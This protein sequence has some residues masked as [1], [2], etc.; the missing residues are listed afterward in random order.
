MGK[1][2]FAPSPSGRMHLG[3]ACSAL[4]SWLSARSADDAFSLRLEDLD[5]RCQSAENARLIVDD[6]AWL[7]LDWDEQL[8]QT[9][10]ISA[11]QSAFET[12]RARDH[13][14]PCFC[15]RADLHAASAPHASDGTPL[16]AGACRS[17]SPEQVAEKSLLRPPAYRIEVPDKTIEFTD[18]HL[19]LVRQ[20]LAAECGDFVLRRSD[21]VFAYQ[22][23]CVVDDALTGCTQVVR[24]DDLL[25]STPRQ[26]FL[27]DRLGYGAPQFFHHPMLLS[28]DGRRLSKRDRDLDLGELRARHVAPEGLVGKLA[29]MLGIIEQP[30]PCRPDELIGEFSWAKLPSHDLV[31]DGSE[32]LA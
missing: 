11:Y 21:G 9:A 17:L 7:G 2:R 3:N 14:Y 13:V 22:L 29:F 18:G 5:D 12:L 27:Y 20:N 19:G 25:S 1:G 24:G 8:T 32:F 4:V 23:V 26:L 28:P 16:Y 6:L 31:V 30:E 15:S 10:R